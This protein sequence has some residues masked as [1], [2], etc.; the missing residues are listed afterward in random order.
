MAVAAAVA[1][2]TRIKR[3][4]ARQTKSVQPRII[5]II[6]K[7][8]S[9]TRII[10]MLFQVAVLVAV[11]AAVAAAILISSKC[12]RGRQTKSSVQTL[13]PRPLVAADL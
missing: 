3:Q 7:N 12:K 2:V 1:V 9:R 8:N 5:T 11:A 6:K 4:R 13:L 10:R